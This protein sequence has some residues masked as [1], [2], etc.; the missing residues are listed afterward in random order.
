MIRSIPQGD[1]RS[2]KKMFAQI[3]SGIFLEMYLV[4]LVMRNSRDVIE[5]CVSLG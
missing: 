2:D 4:F 1:G 5:E 3:I